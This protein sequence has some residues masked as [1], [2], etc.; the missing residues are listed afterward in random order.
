MNLKAGV[1][2]FVGAVA[3]AR[4][5]TQPVE[6]LIE[7]GHW[8][9]ARALVESRLAVN[10]SDAAGLWWM[11]RIKIEYGD[12]DGALP[13]AE[14]A[15]ALDGR[16]ASYRGVLA[17]IYG[18]MAQRT[19]VFRQIGL[20]RRC[21]K[22]LDAAL[23]LDPNHVHLL[24][25]YM[26]Y[27]WEAPGIIGGDKRK[28]R[29]IP[30]RVGRINAAHGYLAA[31]KLAGLERNGSASEELY[32]KAAEA[33]PRSYEAHTSLAGLYLERNPVK[34]DLVEK[35]ARAALSIDAGRVGAYTLL[36]AGYALQGRWSELEVT[37]AQAEKNV[38]D[39]LAPHYVTGNLL[40]RSGKELPRAEAAFRKY[41]TQEPEP[42]APPIWTGRWRLGLAL[43]K[44]G[45]TREAV[46]ELE[47]ALKLKPDSEEVR[48]DLKRLKR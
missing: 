46:S 22:E 29:E 19:S 30:E 2:V 17:Q 26:E 8:K 45:R 27:L 47:A 48:N 14:K 42:D 1:V 28:A 6:A 38:P 11:A 12:L 32:R 31:A 35:H 23:Q 44:M 36:A 10:P 39:N 24:V 18:R 21:K 16:N 4:A 13:L 33:D 37:L 15:V 25:G 40:L 41:L 7:A 9:R 20:A 34:L 3:M 5:Q 43:E